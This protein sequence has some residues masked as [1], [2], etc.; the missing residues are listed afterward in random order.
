MLDEIRSTAQQQIETAERL[1]DTEV[2]AVRT[3]A[4]AELEEAQR[5]AQ[6]QVEEVRR[7][8][9]ERLRSV[10]RD[11]DDVREQLD[12][13]RVEA[14]ASTSDRRRLADDL[15][16]LDAADSLSDVLER[17]AQ[18]AA[19]HAERAAVLVVKGDRL[20][21][22]TRI[23][24]AEPI[25]IALDEAGI[26]ADVLRERRAAARIAG[27]PGR[28]PAFASDVDSRDAAASPVMVAGTVVA[29]LYA[30]AARGSAAARAWPDDLDVL[31][32]YASRLLE[33][34]TVQ[35]AAGIR[36]V[37]ALA[38]PSQPVAAREASGGLS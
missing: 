4:K 36:T 10:T 1:L 16:S 21:G 3:R 6:S 37:R 33:T 34:L 19:R 32:R 29:L 2:T 35:Q 24:F 7:T 31:S 25:D 26:A 20:Q 17:L 18:A 5:T 11:R 13:A 38:R 27:G 22:W 28:V 14:Q 23:G 30:D 12:G 9:D 15:R 8:M